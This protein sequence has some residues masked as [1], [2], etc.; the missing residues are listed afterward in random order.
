MSVFQVTFQIS[1]LSGN[2]LMKGSISATRTDLP[3]MRAAI[4][5]DAETG[6][7]TPDP[8]I[9]S[10]RIRATMCR[11]TKK[12]T[13]GGSTFR[14]SCLILSMTVFIGA[15]LGHQISA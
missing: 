5:T 2:R 10:A 3:N 13:V 4:S 15:S 9:M 11:I 6:S 14:N 7:S 12:N 8:L 1:G